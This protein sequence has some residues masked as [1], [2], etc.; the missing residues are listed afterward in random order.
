MAWTIYCH[1]HTSSGRRYIGQTQQDWRQRWRDHMRDATGKRAGWPFSRAIAEYGADAFTHRILETCA[2]LADANEAEQAWIQSFSTWHP[3]YGF[4]V[5]R[6][7]ARA[8]VPQTHEDVRAR[9]SAAAKARWQDPVKRAAVLTAQRAPGVSAKRSANAKAQ[10]A[11]PVVAARNRAALDAALTPEVYA[12]ARATR[13]AGVD[14]E[15]RDKMR[16]AQVRRWARPGEHE[17]ASKAQRAAKSTPEYKAK[18]AARR[19]G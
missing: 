11:D 6:G 9:M 7:T 15:E 8:T 1:T 5:M 4:N 2:T 13:I 10:W 12:R 19:A 14:D 16:Q 18:L 17:R 3:A